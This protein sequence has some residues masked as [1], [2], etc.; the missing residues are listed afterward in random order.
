[1]FTDRRKDKLTRLY[2]ER[3]TKLLEWI[4]EYFNINEESIDTQCDDL[5]ELIGDG[6]I[7]CKLM[8]IYQPQSI[9]KIIQPKNGKFFYQ[10]I[11]NINAFIS[12]CHNLEVPIVFQTLDLFE[13]KNPVRVVNCLYCLV[14]IIDKNIAKRRLKRKKE[15]SVEEIARANTEL[16]VEKETSGEQFSGILSDSLLH[17]TASVVDFNN[18]T[19]STVVGTNSVIYNPPHQSPSTP[20]NQHPNINSVIKTPQNSVISFHTSP[21]NSSTSNTSSNTVQFQMSNVNSYET[22]NLSILN[23]SHQRTTVVSSPLTKIIGTSNTSLQSNGSNGSNHSSTISKPISN[24]SQNHTNSGPQP[25]KSYL[26]SIVSQQEQIQR[27]QLIAQDNFLRDINSSTN[28]YND[29]NSVSEPIGLQHIATSSTIKTASISSI[30]VKHSFAFSNHSAEIDNIIN[31]TLYN[32]NK[33]NLNSIQNSTIN[34]SN[35]NIHNNNIFTHDT[36]TPYKPLIKSNSNE[37]SLYQKSQQQQQQQ[38]LQ[39][40]TQ[41][42]QLQQHSPSKSATIKQAFTINSTKKSNIC[43][44]LIAF[45]YICIITII[46]II[47]WLFFYTE[48]NDKLSSL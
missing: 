27:D 37:H 4:K 43:L 18:S 40:Q 11:E 46:S 22:S 12:Q 24:S 9:E 39:N 8:N 42:Q 21:S 16:E 2:L 36:D 19:T 10:R 31:N 32:S 7:L 28:N 35:N 15:F 17:S 44:S 5:L 25:N 30:P 34:N 48:N 38:L 6:V 3:K 47:I 41:Q 45:I 33:K 20:Q 29:I 1:M 26:S 23:T 13:N 14:E